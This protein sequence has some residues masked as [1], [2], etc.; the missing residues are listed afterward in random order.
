MSVK[1]RAT[2]NAEMA[3]FI[4]RVAPEVDVLLDAERRSHDRIVRFDL[5]TTV[6]GVEIGVET[7]DPRAV[8]EDYLEDQAI[9]QLAHHLELVGIRNGIVF[10]YP[11]SPE[12]IAVA[13][14]GN[15]SWPRGVNLREVYSDNPDNYPD[16]E[17]EEAVT[18]TEG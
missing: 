7:H 11:G 14:T 8:A 10:F 4:K 15:T 2:A 13:T 16:D 18:L 5:L 9:N 1:N 6:Q 3:A 12:H 17:H